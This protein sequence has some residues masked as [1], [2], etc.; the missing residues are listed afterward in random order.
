M[1]YSRKIFKLVVGCVF[2]TCSVGA[3]SVCLGDQAAINPLKVYVVPQLTASQLYVRWAPVLEWVGRETK[4]CFE[5]MVPSNIP[6][7]ET[8]LL[9]DKPD[10]V[11]MNPYH[12]TMQ[13]RNRYL[14]LVASSDPIFGILMVRKDSKLNNPKDLNGSRITFPAPNAFAASLL[15]RSTLAKEGVSF[16]PVYVKTHSNVYRSV[17]RGDVPAGGGIQSTLTS[18]PTELKS[19]LRTLMET[20]RYTSHPFSA[21]TRVPELIRKNVQDALLKMDQSTEGS[22][23]LKGVFLSKPMVVSYQVNYQP[24]ESLHLEKFVVKSAE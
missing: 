13:W 17:I 18:E 23:L 11:F 24:L 2:S 10:F 9:A 21:N 6:Q 14:P 7:F 22:E 5:L 20:K 16:Q 12:A 19:E 15:I 1:K 4:Q 8:D 3:Y